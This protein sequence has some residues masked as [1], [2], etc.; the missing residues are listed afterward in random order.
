[1]NSRKVNLA[2]PSKTFEVE[3]HQPLF[4]DW[5]SGV[6]ESFQDEKS[7][8]YLEVYNHGN[9]PAENVMVEIAVDFDELSDFMKDH[10]VFNGENHHSFYLSEFNKVENIK[11]E[12]NFHLEEMGAVHPV[13]AEKHGIKIH[14]PKC[15]IYLLNIRAF[16]ENLNLFSLNIILVYKDPNNESKLCTKEFLIEPEIHMAKREEEPSNNKVKYR[17]KGELIIE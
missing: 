16:N 15:Y 1:M 3:L 12:I 10:I 5:G 14:L 8:F 2:I 17:I 7:G 6:E 13:G 9:I 11:H 4:Q